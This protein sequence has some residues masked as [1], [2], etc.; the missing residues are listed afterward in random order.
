MG[1]DSDEIREQIEETRDRLA[2]TFDA[3]AYKADVPNRPTITGMIRTMRERT[4]TVR[5]NPFGIF[6]GAV[7]F[8]FLL[9][10]LL[11]ATGIEN[12]RLSKI[13]IQLK[14]RLQSAGAQIIE[15]IVAGA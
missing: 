9:G 7:A 14:Q 13:S 2:E 10:L 5:E 15:T 4:T 6:F 1:K 11:P 8:G 12:E 3:L